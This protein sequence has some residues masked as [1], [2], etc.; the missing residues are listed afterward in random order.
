M[1]LFIAT[2]LLNHSQCWAKNINIL[3][4]AFNLLG[5]QAEITLKMFFS[6]NTNKNNLI[7]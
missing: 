1:V 7:F 4:I 6:L 5:T 2:Y 3:S